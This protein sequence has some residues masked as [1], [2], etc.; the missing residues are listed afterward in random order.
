MCRPA[1]VEDE[2]V[3]RQPEHPG[4]ARHTVRAGAVIVDDP[5]WSP[6]IA[7]IR[8]VTLDVQ[9]AK[10][11]DTGRLDALRLTWVPGQEPVP[12]I[13]W[14]SDVAKWIEAASY[15]LA[16]HPDPDL[17]RRVDEA[18][19]LLAGAQQEDGYLNTYFTVVE[20]G[21][22]WTDLRDAHELYCAGHLIEAG[23]AHFEATGKRTLLDVVVRYADHIRRVFGPG[24]DQLHG[25]C[26]HPEVELAL[27]KLYRATGNVDYLELAAFFVDERGSQPYFFELEEQ[28]RGTPGY[29]AAQPP[30]DERAQRPEYFREY[31]Q[32][33]LPVREQTEVVG[34]AVRA[35]YLYSAMADLAGEQPTSGLA[36]AVRRLW[37][38][39]MRHRVYVTGGL[40]SSRENEGFT[41]DEDLPNAEA[42]AETCAAIGSVFWA[43]RMTALTGEGRYGD[44]LER[45]LYNG[46]LSGIS[47]DGRSFFYENPLATPSHGP[48]V[49]RSPWFGVACCP[50][51]LARLLTSLGSYI[52]L[53]GPREVL[54]N[55]YIGSQA[56]VVLDGARVRLRQTTDYPWGGRVR[57]V[58]ETDGPARF[59]LALRV[60]AWAPRVRV[61]V[62]GEPVDV[63]GA[64]ADGFVR[65]DRRWT[66]GDAVELELEMPPA[67]VYADPRVEADRGAVA[68]ARGPLVYC[69]EEADNPGLE[70]SAVLREAAATAVPHPELPGVTALAVAGV[71][72]QDDD[73]TDLYRRDVPPRTT[74]TTLLAVPYYAWANRQ[75]GQM[76]VWQREV[77]A[78]PGRDGHQD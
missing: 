41:A 48:Q 61:T 78:D 38:H 19:E 50:P 62:G 72:E 37:D 5:F 76:A 56:S 10:L 11:R 36:P 70:R 8:D 67:R 7:T 52:Y 29:F 22:R 69:F 58:V 13:F 3:R 30:F 21:R 24:P 44:A 27:V 1:A 55:L 51:N 26:G 60:P 14:D 57:V 75:P 63:A 43:H 34:H 77:V 59:T 74:A 35:M 17:E 12:H 32:S 53:V 15:S 6:R 42:Y 49:R 45:A 47:L 16:T 2:A 23:V 28:R 71:V 64:T 9:Y 25:Y 4:G 39:V 40:G 46:V 65:L 33:H 31:N 54:V 66:D 18:I 73:W 68:L 20:P